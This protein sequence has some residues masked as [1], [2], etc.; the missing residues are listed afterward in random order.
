LEQQNRNV[1]SFV[2]VFNLLRFI[3]TQEPT[4]FVAYMIYLLYFTRKLRQQFYKEWALK[5]EVF[6][7]IKT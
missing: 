2:I 4:S 6:Q 3:T 7:D 1:I 5:I